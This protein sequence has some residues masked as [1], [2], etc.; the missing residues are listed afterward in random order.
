MLVS[1]N[2]S[3]LSGDEC[4][5]PPQHAIINCLNRKN[6]AAVPSAENVSAYAGRLCNALSADIHGASWDTNAVQLS[7][8]LSDLDRCVLEGLCKRMGLL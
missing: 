6:T 2:G 1:T 5:K 7:D 8:E 4:S 3:V